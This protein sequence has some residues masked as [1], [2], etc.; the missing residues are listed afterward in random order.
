MKLQYYSQQ[1]HSCDKFYCRLYSIDT[2]SVS[3]FVFVCVCVPVHAYVHACMHVCVCFAITIRIAGYISTKELS[4][5]N[6][7]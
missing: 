6:V 1:N 7:Y 5:L 3:F 4:Q 2:K